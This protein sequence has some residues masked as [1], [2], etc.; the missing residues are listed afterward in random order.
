[1]GASF[2][3][4]GE[5]TELAGCDRLTISPQLLQE[6]DGDF[7]LLERKLNPATTGGTIH[8]DLGNESAFRYELNDDPMTTEKLSHGIRSFVADQMKLESWLK[9]FD[10]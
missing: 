3:N 10:K 1:M 7:G 9:K 2:R 8:Y 4:T 6:L 5:I